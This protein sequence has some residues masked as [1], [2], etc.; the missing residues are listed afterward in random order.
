MRVLNDHG[1]ANFPCRVGRGGGDCSKGTGKLKWITQNHVKKS[2][3][4]GKDK[5]SKFKLR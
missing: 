3:F 1:K 5:K 4:T 2:D